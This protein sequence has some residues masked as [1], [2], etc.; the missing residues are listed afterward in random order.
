MC[1]ASGSVRNPFPTVIGRCGRMRLVAA[2]SARLRQRW[3][4]ARQ[5][6]ENNDD[7]HSHERRMALPTALPAFLAASVVSATVSLD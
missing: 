1:W 5:H 3:G 4:A 7:R 6:R 2:I